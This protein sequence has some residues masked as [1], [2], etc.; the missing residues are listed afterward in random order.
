MSDG[1]SD[2]SRYSR[3]YEADRIAKR[4]LEKHKLEKM[5][6]ELQGG[7]IMPLDGVQLLFSEKYEEG[8]ELTS[9]E[10]LSESGS[11]MMNLREVIRDM[12]RKGLV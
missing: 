11:R 2:S 6:L 4:N 7:T 5:C 12:I 9:T 10:M 1:H 8:T 3:F